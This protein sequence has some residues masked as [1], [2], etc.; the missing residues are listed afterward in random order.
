MKKNQK[1]RLASTA[2]AVGVLAL[3]TACGGGSGFSS[4]GGSGG[5]ASA[6]AGTTGK[7][8]LRV[9]IGSSGT[10]ETNAVRWPPRPPGASRAASR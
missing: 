2:L 5:G 4:N 8:P 10:A 1:A 6:S 3:T 9:L 7:G